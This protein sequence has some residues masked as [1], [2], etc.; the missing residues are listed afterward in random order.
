MASWRDVDGVRRWRADLAAV[1]LLLIVLNAAIAFVL[2]GWWDHVVLLAAAAISVVAAR[3]RGYTP[4]ELGLAREDVAKGVRLGAI[5][6]AV[7]V[8]VITVIVALPLGRGYFD[9]DRFDTLTAGEVVYEVVIRV[10]F[11]T[12]LSE[13][14]L[15]RAVLLAIL[16]A[17]TSTR[18]AVFVS[19][20]LF[21]LWH[22]LTTLGDLDGNDATVG[23][24]GWETVAGVTGVVV[25]TAVAGVGFA[26]LRVRSGSTVA[27]WLVHTAL[28][29][30]TFLAGVV[31]AA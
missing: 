1:L 15:F 22:V 25:A 23:L 3:S 27:P 16:L 20:T 24:T 19:S 9:D 12:A 28:N 18:W 17:A 8:V 13:E 7:V 29:A 4:A 11:V 30:S 2:D 14:I 31:V 6:A 5:V 10:P 21:G 26:W